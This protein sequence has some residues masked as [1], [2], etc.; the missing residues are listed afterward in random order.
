MSDKQ[1]GNHQ[2]VTDAVHPRFREKYAVPKTI[3]CVS[4]QRKFEAFTILNII[5]H[6]GNHFHDRYYSEC[7]YCR[8]KV[9]LYQEH[10][11]EFSKHEIKYYHDCYRSRTQLDK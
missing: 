11:G 6:Y 7:L 5:D 9:H 3:I 8:G 2:T 1:N 4:C 10:Q